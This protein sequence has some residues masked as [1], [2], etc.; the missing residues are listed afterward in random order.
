[1]AAPVIAIASGKG[2]TGKTTVSVNMAAVSGQP[3]TLLDCDVEAPNAHLFLKPN[4]LEQERIAVHVPSLDRN[5][6][7]GC[8]RCH[9]ACRFNAVALLTGFPTFFRELCHSCGNCVRSCPQD[10]LKETPRAVGT[11]RRGE[12]GHIHFTDGVMDVGEARSAPV[13][14]KVRAE[15]VMERVTIVDSPPGTSCPAV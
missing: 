8:G 11:L 15:S 6:C 4:W 9:E 14:D 1:M 10:A 12:T 3:L 7:T 2:G 13:V 5:R